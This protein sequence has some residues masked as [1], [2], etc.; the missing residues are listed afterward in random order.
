MGIARDVLILAN[1]FIIPVGIWEYWGRKSK[2]G[3]VEGS[4]SD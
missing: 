2:S 4:V 1:S 3:I